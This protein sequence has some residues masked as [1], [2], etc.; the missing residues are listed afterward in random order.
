MKNICIKPIALFIL[1]SLIFVSCSREDE[2]KTLDGVSMTFEYDASQFNETT[3]ASQSVTLVNASNSLEYTAVTNAS[4]HASFTSVI[5]GVYS[6]TVSHKATGEERANLKVNP[7]GNEVIVNG[8]RANLRIYEDGDLGTVTLKSG[9]ISSLVI[10]KFYTNGTRDDN[11]KSYRY[12]YYYTIYNNGSEDVDM[13]NKYVG[14]ADQY[15]TNP[16][17]E[18]KENNVYMETV[19]SLGGGV[20][21]PGASRVFC[22]QAVDHTASASKSVDLS[23][24]DYEVRTV[25]ST[26]IDRN[27]PE[28]N[29]VENLSITYTAFSSSDYLLLSKYAKG[30]MN[31]VIFES[32]DVES[33]ALVVADPTKTNKQYFK[34]VPTSSILD[35]VSFTKYK[36]T[37]GALDTEYMDKY[38]RLPSFI[39]TYTY[40]EENSS[41]LGIAFVR[42]VKETIDGR[43]VLVD[44]NQSFEDFA[45]T[46]V[47]DPRD[48][49]VVTPVVQ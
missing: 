3:Y 34:Q 29:Y 35:G 16:F 40:L 11:G 31:M 10:A 30:G 43:D 8:N 1:V 24:A 32:D 36:F 9:V 6:V 25:P 21:S 38:S 46:S 7:A 13:T 37:D 12:D 14:I 26:I 28:N 27:A 49:T 20:L 18:D 22:V 19:V 17:A 15:P 41:Y 44:T 48:F 2:I 23:G 4:G 45:K 39:D 5:P 42:K 47:L 33:L